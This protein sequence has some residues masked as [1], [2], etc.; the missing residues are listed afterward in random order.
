MNTKNLKRVVLGGGLG[1][2]II[3][4]VV[5][6]PSL[7]GFC[8]YGAGA[9]FCY[10][11]IL[12]F[13]PIGQLIVFLSLF[14]I[15]LSL[16]TYWAKDELFRTW[17]NFARWWVL[18]IIGV[19]VLLENEGGGGGFGGGLAFFFLGSFYC[20]LIL[21]SLSAI[22]HTHFTLKYKEQGKPTTRI[23]KAKNIFNIILYGSIG[24]FFFWLFM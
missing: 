15:F 14:L 23:N 3:L 22:L 1:A 8:R 18:V 24:L 11:K 17:W 16:L 2:F 20:I 7:F 13:E 21:G 12:F 9:Q 10:S 4:F 6:M 19:T 5:D